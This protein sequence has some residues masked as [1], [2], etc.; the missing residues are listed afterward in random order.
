MGL[1]TVAMALVAGLF[2]FG[3]KGVVEL[4]GMRT[5]V[6]WSDGDSFKILDGMHK[7]KGTRLSGYNT[8]ES[9]GPVHQW[10]DYT[11][12]DLFFQAKGAGKYAASQVWKC[13]ADSAKV[14]FYGRLLVYCPDLVKYMVA[15]GHGHL[16]AVGDDKVDAEA[17]K[18]Q[19]LAIKLAKGIWEK[20][21]PKAIITSLHSIDENPGAVKAYNRLVDPLT[22]ISRTVEHTEKYTECQVVCME[23]SCMTHVPFKRRYGKDQAPCIAYKGKKR[24]W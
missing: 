6:R 22:G 13:T 18:A 19:L 21:V 3:T 7:G 15:E 20:G 14:D 9:F 5:E 23:G 1:L 17:L 4:N 24:G 16:M 8:L 12:K 10:G 11:A 2:N